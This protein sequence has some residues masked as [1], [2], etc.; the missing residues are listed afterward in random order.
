VT[1]TVAI[2]NDLT[3]IRQ[4]YQGLVTVT[5][6][7]GGSAITPV[8]FTLSVTVNSPIDVLTYDNATALELIGEEGET[9]V[10][11]TFQ[12][13]NIGTQAMALPV[14]S[15]DT[16]ALDLTDGSHSITLSFSDPG[17]INAGETKT[18]TVTASYGDSIDLDT[19]GGVVNVK[20]GTT[21]LD[22]FKLDL[23]VFPEVC[24]D[25]IVKEGDMASRGTAF[26]QLN[27][28]EPDNGDDF[29]PGD[30]IKV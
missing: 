20:T 1:S 29:K 25:G 28:K 18:V 30:D 5:G 23:K 13:K 11:G 4:S 15:F 3:L 8:T 14:S 26:L 17:T 27:I 16:A 9:N 10:T 22:S 21:I 2:P 6:T 12:I 24:E 19:Y 7:E